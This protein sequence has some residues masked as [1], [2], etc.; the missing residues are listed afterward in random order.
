M[1]IINPG[2]YIALQ[3]INDTT[4]TVN[5]TAIDLPALHTFRATM[6][7]TATGPVMLMKGAYSTGGTSL[8]MFVCDEIRTLV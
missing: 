1:A 5:G 7:I 6:P 3:F 4:V 8:S 2:E